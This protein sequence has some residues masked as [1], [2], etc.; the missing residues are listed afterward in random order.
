[1]AAAAAIAGIVVGAG[2]AIALRPS[3]SPM[4]PTQDQL[5]AAIKADPALCPKP[6]APKL[7]I[8]SLE[9]ATAAYRKVRGLPE[10]TL[11]MGECSPNSMGPGVQCTVKFR[12]KPTWN[13]QAGV[14]AFSRGPDG[15]QAVP[16]Y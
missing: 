12:G 14:I 15:W 16:L 3:P 2:G 5:V 1:M 7:E 8:P 4:P 13:E 11:R 6:A 9:E 10:A